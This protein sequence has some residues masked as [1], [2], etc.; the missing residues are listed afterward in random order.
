M[1][2]QKFIELVAKMISSSKTPSGAAVKVYTICRIAAKA[3]GM[4]PDIEVQ[5]RKPGELRCYGTDDSWYVSFEAGPHE[6]AVAAS[7]N[8]SPKGKVLAEPYYS[9]DLCFSKAR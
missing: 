1:T 7:L 9:F 8:V 2:E 3:W 5:L 6:W 4:K